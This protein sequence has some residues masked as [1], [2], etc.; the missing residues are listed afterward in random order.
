MRV[1]LLPSGIDRHVWRDFLSSLRL[2]LSLSTYWHLVLI[3]DGSVE[4]FFL[5]LLPLPT[6][7][8]SS[9]SSTYSLL[10]FSSFTINIYMCVCSRLYW[11]QAH[12]HCQIIVR[13]YIIHRWRTM[14]VRRRR[15]R[16]SAWKWATNDRG[17]DEMQMIISLV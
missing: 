7:R 2:S 5:L 3:G 15:E 8:S 1:L 6:L 13:V 11:G 10:Y 4:N 9:Y 12:S 16:D 14:R 17:L